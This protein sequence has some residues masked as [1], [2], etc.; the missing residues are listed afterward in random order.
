MIREPA[1]AQPSAEFVEITRRIEDL[2][3]TLA[4]AMNQLDARLTAL[5]KS[6]RHDRR[7]LDPL[8]RPA[9]RRTSS[10]LMVLAAARE[11][12]TDDLAG[13]GAA[14]DDFRGT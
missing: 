8:R 7:R 11:F 13:F 4:A 14:V 10:Y 6:L 3:D 1:P 5:A 9:H 12:V 2:R